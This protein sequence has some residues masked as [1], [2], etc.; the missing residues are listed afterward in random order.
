MDEFLEDIFDFLKKD[1]EPELTG[2]TFTFKCRFKIIET[3]NNGYCMEI[4]KLYKSTYKEKSEMDY[5]STFFPM[6]VS[7]ISGIEL[8]DFRINKLYDGFFSI[9]L[10]EN[11]T[12]DVFFLYKIEKE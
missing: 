6:S 5:I 3:T 4:N 1:E 8:N 9:N 2:S 7:D 12:F 11:K 10:Y